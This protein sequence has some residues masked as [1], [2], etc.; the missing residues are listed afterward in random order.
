MLE[1]ANKLKIYQILSNQNIHI[2][3][4]MP[5]AVHKSSTDYISAPLSYICDVIVVVI[6]E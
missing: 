2:M 3:I 6:P 4:K 5:P 1:T